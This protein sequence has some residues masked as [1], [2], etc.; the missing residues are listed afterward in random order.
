MTHKCAVGNE[1]NMVLNTSFFLASV[2]SQVNTVSF[3]FRSLTFLI[4]IQKY[5]SY[6]A[7]PKVLQC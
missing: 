5:F 2:I 1:S 4:V 6:D 7:F 3:G